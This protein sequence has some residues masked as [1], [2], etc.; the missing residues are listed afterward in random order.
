M[1]SIRF[2][3]ERGNIQG[4]KL[5]NEI[6]T[7]SHLINKRSRVAVDFWLGQGVAEE[8]Y[9]QRSATEEQRNSRQKSG[10]IRRT[11]A[12]RRVWRRC[13]LL[14]NPCGCAR[15]SR[16]ASHPE[17]L[18][19]G[20]LLFMRWLLK[21]IKQNANLRASY[22]LRVRRIPALQNI[23]SS[24]TRSVSLNYHTDGVRLHRRRQNFWR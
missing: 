4:N 9:P 23:A 6:G 19:R 12:L 16:L 5:R 8:A 13:S 11:R 18:L 10:A 1:V 14:T 21:P 17:L 7:R 20:L 3:L 15:H 22:N 24:L 2:G